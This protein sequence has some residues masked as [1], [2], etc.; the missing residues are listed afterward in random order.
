M[1]A[2]SL[3]RKLYLLFPHVFTQTTCHLISASITFDRQSPVA[4]S[5]SRVI[6]AS[7]WR[8]SA[9]VRGSC[10]SSPLLRYFELLSCSRCISTE[11]IVRSPEASAHVGQVPLLGTFSPLS[12]GVH[13]ASLSR[14]L[15]KPCF[16]SQSQA[17]LFFG[18][19]SLE[20][21]RRA[22]QTWI[23]AI[24]LFHLS[25][26][27]FK[28][29]LIQ[30]LLQEVQHFSNLNIKLT[31]N[32]NT[33][34][35]LFLL[36]SPQTCSDISYL[37]YNI[38]C[39]STWLIAMPLHDNTSHSIWQSQTSQSKTVLNLMSLQT[40]Q[41]RQRDFWRCVKATVNPWSYQGV[42]VE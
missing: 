6:C 28:T 32:T 1:T 17:D 29:A 25:F 12:W 14:H 8:L 40:P 41:P 7:S 23:S 37:L 35:W 15:R 3:F 33:V 21:T 42:I 10:L 39:S 11:S 22:L 31:G 13:S 20:I 19:Q 2:S 36:I 9:L 5:Y 30:F 27:I 24:C 16:R 26:V 38:K 34:K 4:P 18:T